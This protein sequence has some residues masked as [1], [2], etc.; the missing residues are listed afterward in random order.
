MVHIELCKKISRT[1]NKTGQLFKPGIVLL[2]KLN[3]ITE[4]RSLSFFNEK[5]RPPYLPFK[6]R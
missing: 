3:K 6:F 2:L 5:Y 1:C 4:I